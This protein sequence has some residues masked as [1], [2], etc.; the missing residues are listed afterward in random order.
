MH[1]FTYHSKDNL[2]LRAQRLADLLQCADAIAI[3][4]D[5]DTSRFIPV[6]VDIATDFAQTLA[7]ELD[8]GEVSTK[9][10]PGVCNG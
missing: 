8:A 7:N 9:T 1:N 10:E 2:L 3:S 6:L 5:P 4:G